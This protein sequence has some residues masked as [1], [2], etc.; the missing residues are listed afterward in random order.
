MELR[1]TREVTSSDE[2]VVKDKLT[3][4]RTQLTLL[5]N[6]QAESFKEDLEYQHKSSAVVRKAC[7][8][9]EERLRSHLE[10]LQ[11]EIEEEEAR[12][13]LGQNLTPKNFGGDSRG[14]PKNTW[15]K[16]KESWKD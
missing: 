15:I 4:T 11:I 10:N 14:A 6:E 5:E 3:R 12:L 13:F 2:A 16:S 9:E 7:Q 8:D 1:T